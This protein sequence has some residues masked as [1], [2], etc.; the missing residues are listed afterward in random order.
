MQTLFE[1]HGDI[2]VAKVV[3]DKLS[4]KSLGY[5]FVKFVREEDA[6]AAIEHKNGFLLGHKKLK[7]SLA[8]PPSTEI[9]NC[10]LFI[11]NLPKEFTEREVNELFSQVGNYLSLFPH[12][13]YPKLAATQLISFLTVFCLPSQFGEIIESRVLKDRNSKSNKGVAFVQ[14]N[15]RIQASH[16]TYM[17]I[18]FGI[19]F[20]VFLHL[21]IFHFDFLSCSPELERLSPSSL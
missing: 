10:K 13:F 6:A 4:K 5:G 14:F 3:K 7:V 11:T 1:E 2:A 17:I 12:L 9:R 19:A 18:L 21:L 15:L 8:R 20:E 16:G